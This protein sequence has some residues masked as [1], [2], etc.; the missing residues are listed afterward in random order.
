MKIDNISIIK[1][2]KLFGLTQVALKL[3]YYLKADA[4]QPHIDLDKVNI[5]FAPGNNV[6][7]ENQITEGVEKPKSPPFA[8]ALINVIFDLKGNHIRK[9]PFEL[10]KI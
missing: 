7:C 8:T 5:V 1:F 3:S 2:L 4:E 9:L 10:T 6:K